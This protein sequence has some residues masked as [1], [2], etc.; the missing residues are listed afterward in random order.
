MEIYKNLLLDNLE[1]E[2]WRDV[3][4]YEG[5][6]QVSNFGRV[7]S[8]K[9]NKGVAREKLLKTAISNGYKIVMLYR[10]K[11]RKT[12]LVHRL[13]AQAFIENNN[14]YPC[15]NHKDECK[16]NN[17]VENRE[18]C[19]NKYNSNFGTRNARASKA[20]SKANTNNPKISKQ[21]YQYTKDGEL[22]AVWKSTSECG[23]NGYNF[24]HVASCCRG[25]IKSH[26]GYIWSYTPL[27]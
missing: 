7:K 11:T 25:E 4:G 22:I 9:D 3:V 23:R 13:V 16:I 14:N 19:T 20:I 10:N 6:Y 27:I 1:N 12:Y 24:G 5:L 21:V 2:I 26:K 8:L 18:R 17:S 15:I